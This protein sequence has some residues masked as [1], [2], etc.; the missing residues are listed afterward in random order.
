[1]SKPQFRVSK[2][3]PMKDEA[4]K[5]AI[6]LNPNLKTFGAKLYQKF[7]RA[8]TDEKFSALRN[9]DKSSLK[10]N[11]NLVLDLFAEIGLLD[12][13]AEERSLGYEGTE[14]L[15]AYY[16][17]K[18]EQERSTNF[19]DD[20]KEKVEVEVVENFQSEYPLDLEFDVATNRYILPNFSRKILADLT[21]TD[22]GEFHKV[23]IVQ[24]GGVS[25]DNHFFMV[26]IRKQKGSKEPLVE[27]FDSSPQI[28]RSG[29]MRCQEQVAK[30]VLGSFLVLGT[31]NDAFKKAGLVITNQNYFY[32]STPYQS[33][34]EMFF[35]HTFAME[36]AREIARKKFK[37]YEL[38]LRD[39]YL[40]PSV[41][42]GMS[43]V[44]ISWDDIETK[45]IANQQVMPPEGTQST[46]KSALLA[47]NRFAGYYKAYLKQTAEIVPHKIRDGS[48]ETADARK[49]RYTVKSLDDKGGEIE[50]NRTILE[51]SMRQ[52]LH[53]FEILS[54]EFFKELACGLVVPE[55]SHYLRTL[56]DVR[57][58]P[59][60][61]VQQC[62]S[63]FKVPNVGGVYGNIKTG[64]NSLQFEIYCG[65]MRANKIFDMEKDSLIGGLFS[66]TERREQDLKQDLG[67]DLGDHV[68]IHPSLL[69]R[70]MIKIEIPDIQKFITAMQEC[71]TTFKPVYTSSL[72][73]SVRQGA[74]V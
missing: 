21:K 26:S 70:Q 74:T 57:V 25:G 54:S 5:R 46:F 15:A 3:T 29:L 67:V 58:K 20:E 53:M 18:I 12:P 9:C 1:M 62:L 60:D 35:C 28:V 47:M 6:E 33:S 65:S 55:D 13:D 66:I 8:M 56:K 10:E 50:V 59:A 37:E 73:S 38:E 63:H 14:L 40:Y 72:S 71:K 31:V 17:Y 41:F 61:N 36:R 43:D 7:E 48:E 52:R 23:Y 49:N 19:R 11:L 34:V 68:E 27:V 2:F 64:D 51:K 45:T 39:S 4:I 42:G 44:P 24:A 69:K 32:N 22:D 30:G 16:I